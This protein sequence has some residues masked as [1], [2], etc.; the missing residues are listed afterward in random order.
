MPGTSGHSPDQ[1]P[2][3]QSRRGTHTTP[4]GLRVKS[5]AAGME[6]H[7]KEAS[8]SHCLLPREPR[9][10]L[11]PPRHCLLHWSGPWLALE[12]ALPPGLRSESGQL[13]LGPLTPEGPAPPESSQDRDACGHTSPTSW[14]SLGLA[15]LPGCLRGSPGT[16]IIME[17]LLIRVGERLAGGHRE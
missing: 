12:P 8:A 2:C 9:D 7:W 11:Q 14:V 6:G 15:H 10:G 4:V 3:Q 1:S 17:M 13:F 5:H 16:L